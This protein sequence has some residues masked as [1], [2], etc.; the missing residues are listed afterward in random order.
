MRSLHQIVNRFLTVFS[1][2]AFLQH[3]LVLGLVLHH[4]Y[5]M[6]DFGPKVNRF[7]R[8]FGLFLGAVSH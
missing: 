6:L 1:V 7:L 8:F 5:I 4:V 3:L 2:V